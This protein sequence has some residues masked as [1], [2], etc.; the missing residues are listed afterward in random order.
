MSH[1]AML[2]TAALAL[3]LVASANAAD[4][5]GPIITST[6][7]GPHPGGVITGPLPDLRPIPSRALM[8][9]VSIKNYGPGPAAA[10]VATLVCQKV[11]VTNGGQCPDP[12]RVP[13]FEDP[14]YPNAVVVHVPALAPGHVYSLKLP[15]WDGLAW[16]SGSYQLTLRADAGGTVA[17][18]NEG[19]NVGVATKVVP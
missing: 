18:T 17:E 8:G 5:R 12:G 7:P 16:T 13:E 15:F 6:P 14:A 11:G 3:V 2:T 1:S 4:G 19:N 9:T 10:S